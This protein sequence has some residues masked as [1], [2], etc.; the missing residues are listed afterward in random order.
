MAGRP[1]AGV[2][3]L[4]GG[5]DAGTSEK[6]RGEVEQLGGT[7]A[8]NCGREEPPDVAVADG[9]LASAYAVG[10]RSRGDCTQDRC[11]RLSWPQSLVIF[12]EMGL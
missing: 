8:A 12:H 7:P 11:R 4:V 9:V 2:R 3:V 1:L 10:A 5:R 6:L